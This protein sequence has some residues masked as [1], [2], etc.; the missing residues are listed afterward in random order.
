LRRGARSAEV[1]RAVIENI[2]ASGIADF[3]SHACTPP[4][5]QNGT[6]EARMD[7]LEERSTAAAL[8]QWLASNA[9]IAQLLVAWGEILV[10]LNPRDG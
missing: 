8:V 9:Y 2:V 10:G 7:D 5:R 4:C 1:F 6:R 3:D